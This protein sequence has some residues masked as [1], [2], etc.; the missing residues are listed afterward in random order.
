PESAGGRPGPA[1]FG[2]GGRAATPTD[3]A[4]IAGRLAADGFAGGAIKLDRAAAEAALAPIAGGL[5]IDLAAAATAILDLAETLLAEATRL[6]AV[7][8]GL[9]PRRLGLVALGGAGPLHAAGIA[10]RLGIERVLIPARPGL[11]AAAG[12]LAAPIE[13]DTI[14]S[15]MQLLDNR[16]MARWADGAGV[17]RIVTLSEP[18]RVDGL[19]LTIGANETAAALAAR[20]REAC[21]RQFGHAGDASPMV[22]RL[23]R[24]ER[25]AS[26]QVA[27]DDLPFPSREGPAAMA[28]ADCAIWIPSGWRLR[29]SPGQGAWL[30]RAR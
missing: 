19:D 23:R 30:E 21:R 8:R 26:P 12:L 24:V 4:L 11:G 7:R 25:I 15:P 20:F 29:P 9:D 1:C 5:G 2:L 17:E 27:I 6:V 18:D 3:A 16:S 14:D 13:I 22:L 10:A 28:R